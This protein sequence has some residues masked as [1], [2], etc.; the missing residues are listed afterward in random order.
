MLT[1]TE[2]VK[3]VTELRQKYELKELLGIAGLSRSTYYYVLKSCQK[4]DKHIEHKEMIKAIFEQHKAR[5]GY[6]RITLELKNREVYLNHKTVLKLMNEMGLHC[7]V[8]RKKYNSFRGEMNK[9]AAN[10][11]QRD[12]YAKKPNEKWTTDVTE[13]A[14]LG[15]KVYLSPVLDMY[16]SEIIAYSISQSPNYKMITDMLEK[17]FHKIPD[18]TDLIFHSDQGWCYRLKDY[19]ERLEEKGIRQSMSRKGNCLDN[20]IME[21]FFGLLK[22]EMF[23]GEVFASVED[24][25]RELENYIDYYNHRRIKGKL[26]GLSPVDYRNQSLKV[27]YP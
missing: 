4:E 5:Y 20:A 27:S 15:K 8:R 1:K 10:L 13:F 7:K 19:Q 11:I 25:I 2:K 26:K 21:N 16:N 14:L 3:A 12:F 23:Y 18:K 22:S 17:A 9:A 6:R 24:F